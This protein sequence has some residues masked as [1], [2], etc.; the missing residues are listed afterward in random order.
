MGILSRLKKSQP[1]QGEQKSMGGLAELFNRGD[2]GTINDSYATQTKNGYDVNPYVYRAIDIRSQA[3]SSIDPIIYDT[4]GNVIEDRNHPLY[5]L[6]KRP[7]PRQSWRDIVYEVESYLAI[8]GNAFLYPIKTVTGIQEIWC[9][10]PENVTYIP[11]NNIFDPVLEWHVNKGDGMLVLEP[12][13]LIHIHTFASDD[14]VL[15]TSPLRPASLSIAQQNS[16]R[17][18][19]KSMMQN[20]AKPS[21]KLLVPDELT[22]EEF[23]RLKT[24]LEVGYS[25]AENTGKVMVLDGGKDAQP[26]GFS[27]TDMEFNVGVGVNAREIEIV[28]GVASEL[29][30]DNVNKTYASTSEAKKIFAEQTVMPLA[31]DLYDKL[32]HGLCPYYKDV[33]YI[34]FDVSQIDALKGDRNET[35][36]AVANAN[37]LTINEMRELLSYDPVPDG[38][39][40]LQPMGNIPLSEV[41][42]PVPTID[43]D[44]RS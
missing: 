7:N 42:A 19:N 40:I 44:D 1:S 29:L 38:D 32:T 41:T 22:V 16:A 6:L 14:P 33:D 18:W 9:I 35:I 31:T 37:F 28:L 23:N 25:G 10:S 15:G 20:G 24:N 8:N 30:N 27:A 5:K 2:T 11:S 39:V 21:L 17:Q 43:P 13:D 3:V 34:G 12:G 26:V 4:K 36:N